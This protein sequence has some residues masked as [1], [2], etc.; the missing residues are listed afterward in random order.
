MTWT[1]HT[2]APRRAAPGNLQLARLGEAATWRSRSY[3]NPVGTTWQ[4]SVELGGRTEGMFSLGEGWKQ[5]SNKIQQ[6]SNR[7]PHFWG[8][9]T[10]ESAVHGAFLLTHAFEPTYEQTRNL[11]KHGQGVLWARKQAKTCEHRSISERS[12][13]DCQLEWHRRF[14]RG[15]KRRNIEIEKRSAA[16]GILGARTLLG[17]PGLTP[18]NN[19][20]PRLAQRTAAAAHSEHGD[21]LG[22]GDPHSSLT[23]VVEKWFLFC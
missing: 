23:T 13:V 22:S 9:L 11:P 10:A 12:T 6:G 3:G 18:R 16:C 17:A 21:A 2:T 7:M 5:G 20:R 4:R 14:S 8:E 19:Q 15:S 1:Q